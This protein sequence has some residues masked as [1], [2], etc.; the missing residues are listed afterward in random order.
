[1]TQIRRKQ[2]TQPNWQTGLKVSLVL[3]ATI[4]IALMLFQIDNFAKLHKQRKQQHVSSPEQLLA[5]E[6]IQQKQQGNLRQGNS[7]NQEQQQQQT[8]KEVPDVSKEEASPDTQQEQEQQSLFFEM[9]LANLKGDV[10]TGTVVLQV[11]PE[12]A[13]L[14]AAHFVEL[15]AAQFYDQCRFFRVLPNFVVQFGIAAEPSVQ[16]VWKSKILQDDKYNVQTN[17]QGTL[18]YATSGKNTRTTQ[19]FINTKDNAFLD[20][21]GFTPF[22]K[23][24]KGMEW[25]AAVNDEYKEE[26]VQG[27]IVKQGND[28]LQRQFPNLSYIT[29]IR[30]LSNP[31]AD[32]TTTTG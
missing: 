29:T 10:S 26:P 27:K 5:Q 24:V 16:Q 14:G 30:Q 28:Y 3:L 19:L 1:M 22:A 2:A 31:P 15:V 8:P 13:P 7:N 21:Q 11:I 23:I 20:K 32:I 17:A 25:I 6:F 4:V 12:W 18:T 9:T